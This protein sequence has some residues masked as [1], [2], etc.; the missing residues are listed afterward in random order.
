MKRLLI[1]TFILAINLFCNAAFAKSVKFIQVTD[2]HT[3]PDNTQYLRDFVNEVNK[4]Y[5][6]IDFVIFTGDNIDKA[7]LSDLKMFL[8]EIKHLHPRTY[9]IMGNHNVFKSEH[10]DKKLYM[11]TVRKELGEYHSNKPNYVFK[12]KGIVFVTMDGVKE[13]IPGPNGYYKPAELEW[14]DKTLTKYKNNKVVIFQHFSLLDSPSK[15][16]NLYKKEEYLNVLNK[17]KNVIANSI[18]TLSYKP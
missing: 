15:S 18:R 6:D 11:E 16:H 2:M 4:K 12:V 1:I 5:N 17:H 13:V 8:N 9:V 10:L 14:L 3:T 7:R